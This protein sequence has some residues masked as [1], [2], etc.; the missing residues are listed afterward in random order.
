MD[1][2]CLKSIIVYITQ[3]LV[4][5][6]VV[7]ASIVNLSRQQENKEMWISLLCSTIGYVLPAPKLNKITETKDVSEQ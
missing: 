1:K 5:L 2:I 7:I 6:G 4:I 3:M